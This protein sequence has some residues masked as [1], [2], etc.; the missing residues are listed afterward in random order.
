[1]K[2]KYY[3]DGN[4]ISEPMGWDKFVTEIKRDKEMKSIMVTRDLS[5][6]FGAH[7]YDYF[8]TKID[9]VGYCA[10]SEILIYRTS[11][12]TNW[13]LFHKGNIY[14]TDISFDEKRK[15]CTAKIQD[16]SFYSY[17]NNNFS[18][19]G[20]IYSDKSKNGVTI[21]PPTPEYVK[22]T[23]LSTGNFIPANTAGFEYKCYFVY[24]VFKYLIDF[25]TDGKVQFQSQ[26]FDVGGIYHN[27]VITTGYVLRYSVQNGWNGAIN[28]AGVNQSQ[29]NSSFPQINLK[30]FFDEMHKRFNLIYWIENS[31]V[32]PIIRIESEQFARTINPTPL[33]NV[34]I[35]ELIHE[36]DN[37]FLYSNVAMGSGATEEQTP[38]T[39]FPQT[40]NLVGFK[41]EEFAV[42]G[43]CNLDNTLQLK[44]NYIHDTNVIQDC[45]EQGWASVFT[46]EYDNE[47]F[48]INVEF[49]TQVIGGVT[50]TWWQAVVS[51]W[52][53]N[54]TPIYYNEQLN[55]FNIIQRFFNGIPTALAQYTGLGDNTFKAYA[56]TWFGGIPNVINQP[57][58]FPQDFA[59]NGFDPNNNYDVLTN[60]YY[61]PFEG[62]FSFQITIGNI[63]SDG[64]YTGTQSNTIFGVIIYD[65]L[66]VQQGVVYQNLTAS[67]AGY[68]S[69]VV[70]SFNPVYMGIGWYAQVGYLWNNLSPYPSPDELDYLT[71]E[72]ISAGNSGEINYSNPDKT[73]FV[74][75]SFKIPMD[76]AEL[77]LIENNIRGM[78][79]FRRFKD[80]GTRYGWIKSIRYNHKDGLADVV[81][82]A[83]KNELY[84]TIPPTPFP[85]SLVGSE[86]REDNGNELRED[87]SIELR[88]N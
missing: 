22:F 77:K 50:F 60:R 57:I 25:I 86:L 69:N 54:T 34:Y 83:S 47:L 84:G 30:D 75:Y 87:G 65:S 68:F 41:D 71:F 82:L 11:D 52:L 46:N 15:E 78:I 39:L 16:D 14:L 42:T 5:L 37:E 9:S 80:L 88:E 12:E 36:V 32:N 23:E 64:V 2:Y 73:P 31:G 4:L 53:S 28:P 58:V 70:L 66:N 1:M 29:F 61:S 56:P 59:P 3:L 24:D 43:Q 8:T 51:N 44:S 55:N 13:D 45:T 35:D 62:I 74:K 17:I 49:V 18:V 6:T 85:P 33:A 7:E 79:P 72:C 10:E 26:T 81:L 67:G 63:F 21:I 40:L 19:G 38:F 76:Y 27:Y 20:Y 48:V